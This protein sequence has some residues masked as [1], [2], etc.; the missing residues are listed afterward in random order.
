MPISRFMDR[1]NPDIVGNQTSFIRLMVKPCLDALSI[2]NFIFKNNSIVKNQL[3]E[4]LITWEHTVVD[5]NGILQTPDTEKIKMLF[6]QRRLL[7][8]KSES[9]PQEIQALIGNLICL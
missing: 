2:S 4:N 3:E 9:D 6:N 1:N 5:E 8:D 7:I